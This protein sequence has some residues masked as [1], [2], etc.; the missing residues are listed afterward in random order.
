MISRITAIEILSKV[1]DQ[2]DLVISSTG[3]ISRE[4]FYTCDRN[5]NFYMIGSMGLASA[6][7]LGLAIEKPD[8][9]V[10]VLDGD[11][12]AL[13]SLGTIPLAGYEAPSNFNHIV[14]D[15]EAYESTGAQPSISTK[16]SIKEIGISSGYKTVYEVKEAE[17]LKSVLPKAV[18][19]GP[20]MVVIKVSISSDENIPR[21]KYTPEQIRD[22]FRTHTLAK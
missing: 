6:M 4:L 13:M 16:V 5:T 9:Q 18:S 19:N 3:M 11:G 8:R 7:G 2:Q 21:V 22:R 17:Q 20:S 14:L 15:N 10:W 1:F 12:S